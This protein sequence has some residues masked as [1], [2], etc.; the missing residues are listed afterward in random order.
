M[1]KLK[2]SDLTPKRLLELGFNGGMNLYAMLRRKTGWGAT[3]C[4]RHGHCQGGIGRTACHR[5]AEDGAIEPWC[6]VCKKQILASDGEILLACRGLRKLYGKR[7]W[8][9]E[10]R[11][12]IV[13]GKRT[14]FMTSK[15]TPSPRRANQCAEY[16]G[17]PVL[18]VKEP[19]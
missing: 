2:R 15:T 10:L 18:I 19:G 13:D 12:G 16:K 1:I 6:Y 8:F 9:S 3:F 7:K 17:I 11:V 14:I 4:K 5:R